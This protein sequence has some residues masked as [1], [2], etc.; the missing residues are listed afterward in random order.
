MIWHQCD[1]C[2]GLPVSED[3]IAEIDYVIHGA[4]H[5]RHNDAADYM[6]ASIVNFGVAADIYRKSVKHG[7]KKVIYLSG[8]NFLRKPLESLITEDHAVGPVTP[9]ALA[10]L[11]GEISLFAMLKHSPTTPVALRITSPIPRTVEELHETV[12]KHWVTKARAGQSVLIFGHGSRKQDYVSTHDVAAA[13]ESSIRCD[14]SGIFN[15]ASGSPVSNLEVASTIASRYGVGVE[16]HGVDSEEGDV[17]NVSIARAQREL[18]Y[19]PSQSAL[20][21]MRELVN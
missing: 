18:A 2:G 8:M 15:I 3:F 5:I 9:Y 10:K 1:L 13:V 21:C 14:V 7:V 12:I 19:S 6:A 20:D 17:W 11:W 4:T 16:F